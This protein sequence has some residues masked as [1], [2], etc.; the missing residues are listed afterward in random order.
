MIFGEKKAHMLTSHA[1]ESCLY[2][3]VKP[4]AFQISLVRGTL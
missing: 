3:I 2:Y 1:V 4:I